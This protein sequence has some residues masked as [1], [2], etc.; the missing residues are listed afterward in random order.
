MLADSD[1]RWEPGLLAAV[2]A[3]FADPAVGGVGTRQNAY[4]ARPACG[5]GWPTG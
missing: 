1:T 2:L 3:P 4:L 5:G